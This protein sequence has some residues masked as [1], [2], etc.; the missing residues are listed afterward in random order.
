MMWMDLK[1]ETLFLAKT[2][3]KRQHFFYFPCFSLAF[4]EGASFLSKRA[5]MCQH[6]FLE[7]FLAEPRLAR[8][9]R[10]SVCPRITRMDANY[11]LLEFFWRDS[12]ANLFLFGETRI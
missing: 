10:D 11:F 9:S 3:E 2:P 5:K 12:R 4:C 8:I 6:F 1:C 7:T